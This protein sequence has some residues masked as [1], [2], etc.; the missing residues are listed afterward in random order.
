[1]S[2]PKELD[3]E[4]NTLFKGLKAHSAVR[5]EFLGIGVPKGSGIDLERSFQSLIIRIVGHGHKSKIAWSAVWVG[6]PPEHAHIFWYK[7]YVRWDRLNAMWADITK[8]KPQIYSK[9]IKGDKSKRNEMRRIVY[10]VVEGQ[11]H[12]ISLD[13]GLPLPYH[14]SHSANWLK[15]PKLTK[16]QAEKLLKSQESLSEVLTYE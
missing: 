7:P 13:T 9:T 12:H 14:F 1:M 15:K 3:E 16:K 11:Q 6:S 10:Y 4:A 5:V 8:A 2:R